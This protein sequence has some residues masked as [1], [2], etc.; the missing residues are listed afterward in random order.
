MQVSRNELI[1]LIKDQEP[2]LGADKPARRS[3]EG[4]ELLW[5]SADNVGC[6][7]L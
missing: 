1:H 3:E 2:N 7:L 6:I 5:S 4:M